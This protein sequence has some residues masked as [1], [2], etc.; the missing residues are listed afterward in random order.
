MD[1]EWIE[2][3]ILK[4][5]DQKNKKKPE[6]QC[7]NAACKQKNQKWKFNSNKKL[8]LEWAVNG[9]G[10]PLRKNS[11]PNNRKNSKNQSETA[12]C[13][14]KITNKKANFCSNPAFSL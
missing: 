14:Q 11:D 8:G 5:S 6:N 10:K 12:A 4:K 13:E 3:T 9:L 7:Q 2:K 1:Y